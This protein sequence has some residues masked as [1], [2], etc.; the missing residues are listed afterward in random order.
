MRICRLSRTPCCQEV[1][2]LSVSPP[3]PE[4]LEQSEKSMEFERLRESWQ[5]SVME[6]C[7]WNWTHQDPTVQISWLVGNSTLTLD[8][9]NV[10][11][12]HE[13]FYKSCKCSNRVAPTS[14]VGPAMS[15]SQ[16]RL[17]QNYWRLRSPSSHCSGQN[18]NK[19][20]PYFHGFQ[21]SGD[22]ILSYA[23]HTGQNYIAT[24]LQLKLFGHF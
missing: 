3:L 17:G 15:V 12:F 2:S 14:C 20:L 16:A 13:N 22:S 1:T 18:L 19:N 5:L 11:M 9:L 23:I 4:S 7:K 10:L 21:T 6:A 24:N 8:N